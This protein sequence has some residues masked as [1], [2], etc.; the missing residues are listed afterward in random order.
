[1]PPFFGCRPATHSAVVAVIP[2]FQHNQT[3]GDPVVLF[4]PNQSG[5]FYGDLDLKIATSLWEIV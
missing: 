4:A 3:V 5:N 2:C 1:M